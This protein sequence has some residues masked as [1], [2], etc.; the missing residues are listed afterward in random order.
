MKIWQKIKQAFSCC[1]GN[2]DTSYPTGQ[3]EY[4]GKT[5][6]FTRL[7][8]YGLSSLEPEG[9][10]VLVL[11]SQGQEAVKLGIPSAMQHRLKGLKE[12]EVAIYNSKTETYIIFFKDGT[13]F[14]N[15]SGV[16]DGDVQVTGDVQI[17]GNLNVDGNVTIGG[18]LGVTGATTMTSV[19][20]NSISIN[21]IDFS[22]HVHGGVT[23]GGGTTGGPQ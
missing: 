10:Y 14:I 7:L 22:S 1:P 12:G 19:T 21:G 23:T 17:D 8:P 4:N 9:Y 20:C 16:I 2:D 11:N 5:A 6:T 18:T 15:C 13:F 3:C